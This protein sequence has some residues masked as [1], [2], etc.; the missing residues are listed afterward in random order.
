MTSPKH[1]LVV[2]CLVRNAADEILLVRHG[3]RGWEI[4]QGRVE[5]GEDLLA[6]AHREVGEEAGIVMD[7][8]PLAVI[9]AKLTPP[10]AVVFAFLARHRGGV[11]RGCEECP[12]VGWFPSAEALRQV[13]NPVN[14]DRLRALL[15]FTGKVI[16][17]SYRTQPFAPGIEALLG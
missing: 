13:D 7:L 10:P 6:A 12:E 8:G 5:E 2:G 9:H 3:K 15:A 16:Y 4:P 14:L 17:R 11:A 1:T